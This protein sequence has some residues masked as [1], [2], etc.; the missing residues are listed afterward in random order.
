VTNEQGQTKGEGRWQ[1]TSV[2]VTGLALK[3][4]ATLRIKL[5]KATVRKW[6]I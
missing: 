3:L 5:T 2:N 6:T 1:W 4:A